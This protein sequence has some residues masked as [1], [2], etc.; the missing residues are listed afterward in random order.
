MS[1]PAARPAAG[2][3]AAEGPP[4]VTLFSITYNQ[5]ERAVA[6]LADAMAQRYPADRLEI[7]M[8]D[9]GSRD[10]TPEA[11]AARAHGARQRVKLLSEEHV[12]DYRSAALWNRCIAAA[13]PETE[14][15][16]QVDDVR[17]P[18]DFVA[19]HVAWH[20]GAVPHV[21]TGAKFEG[22]EETWTLSACRR[23]GLAGERGAPAVGIVA[24]AVWGASLSY[25]RQLMARACHDPAERPFDERMTGY[26]Y[27]EVE[28][29]YRLQKAGGRLVYDPGVGVFHRDHEDA[30]ER[31]RGLERRR[32]M[33]AGLAHNAAYFCSKHGV[34]RVPRW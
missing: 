24:S 22:P 14:V 15:F 6:T 19:R 10:G 9:D 17:F 8:L 29:A 13:A 34:E 32:L 16:V 30:G 12:G 33:D 2:T 31:A 18:P 5:R 4:N 20:R 7:V 26:G 11:L 28:F 25:P 21:V 27:H 3:P 1:A 23:H